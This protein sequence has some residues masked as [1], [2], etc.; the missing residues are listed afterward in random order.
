MNTIRFEWITTQSQ[1]DAMMHLIEEQ[2]LDINKRSILSKELMALQCK[3]I[4]QRY[5]LRSQG[6]KM[7]L[8]V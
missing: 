5:S 1:Y 4:G 2:L 6:R 3:L 7:Q 8:S